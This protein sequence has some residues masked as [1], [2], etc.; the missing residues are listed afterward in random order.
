MIKDGKNLVEKA[1]PQ[2]KL[3][4]KKTYAWLKLL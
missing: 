4:W 2:N 3:E 1:I